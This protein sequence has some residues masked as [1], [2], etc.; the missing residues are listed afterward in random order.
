MANN[1]IASI[2]IN[3]KKK[4]KLVIYALNKSRVSILTKLNHC[5]GMYINNINNSVI[6]EILP[7]RE[8]FTVIFSGLNHTF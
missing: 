8:L 6:I 7:L 4:V 2:G 3:T 5:V 1:I